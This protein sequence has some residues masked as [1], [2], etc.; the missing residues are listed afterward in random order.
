MLLILINI[1]I[2][3]VAQ[4]TAASLGALATSPVETEVTTLLNSTA[5]QTGTVPLPQ[6]TDKTQRKVSSKVPEHPFSNIFEGKEN[7][8]IIPS[9]LS[10]PSNL[11]N[12]DILR[13]VVNAHYSVTDKS[14]STNIYFESSTV[15]ERSLEEL[16]NH[17]RF[18]YLGHDLRRRGSQGSKR[19]T[20]LRKP[21]TQ[22][23]QDIRRKTIIETN[24]ERRVLNHAKF[25]LNRA[26]LKEDTNTKEDIS[27]LKNK[28]ITNNSFDSDV[29]RFS[30]IEETI[31]R[32]VHLPLPTELKEQRKEI[33]SNHTLETDLS[34]HEITTAESLFGALDT[35]LISKDQKNITTNKEDFISHT[36]VTPR[37]F[38]LSRPNV[39]KSTNTIQMISTEEVNSAVNTL[40]GHSLMHQPRVQNIPNIFH[41]TER[42]VFN[43][44]KEEMTTTQSST[45]SEE[46]ITTSFPAYDTSTDNDMAEGSLD[47]EMEMY[48]GQYHEVEPG[49][50]SETNPGQYHEVNPGQ[51]HE[52]NPGQ[53]HETNPGQYHEIHPGQEVQLNI[54]FNPEEETKTYNVHKKTGDYIIGEVGKINVNDG[55][56]ME[57]V[58]YTAVDGMVNQAQIAEILKKFFGTNT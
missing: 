9:Q 20:N 1:V 4:G 17:A 43:S 36:R 52:F 33:P 25:V 54:E 5:L 37:Q 49:Q 51:Y 34:T 27:P 29:S 44:P 53:Y 16:L 39:N 35:V 38:N 55:Q 26:N 47:G 42:K 56:T 10:A 45:E 13:L 8:V 24:I 15:H 40:N 48:D 7:Q 58:R 30:N 11:P 19:T 32:K 2:V 12:S 6:D 18:K 14:T 46:S 22:K 28:T 50:Y 57:G 23:Q 41:R 31:E 3:L 21:K